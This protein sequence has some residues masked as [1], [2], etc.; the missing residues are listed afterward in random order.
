MKLYIFNF[1]N[2]KQFRSLQFYALIFFSFMLNYSNIFSMYIGKINCIFN[3][4]IQ[5]LLILIQF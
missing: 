4:I 3:T 1:Y 5:Y 2:L